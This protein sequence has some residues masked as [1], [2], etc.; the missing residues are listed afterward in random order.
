MVFQNYALFPHKTVAK[1]IAYPLECRRVPKSE[2]HER[3]H[4]ALDTVQL[5]GF[6]ARLPRELSGGQQQR[7]AIARALVFEPKLLLMDEPLGAL[8]RQLREQMQ[9]EIRRLHERLGITVIYVTHDQAEALVMSDRIAVFNQ[10][11]IEQLATPAEL[12]EHPQNS[13]VAQ[14]V[15]ENNTFVGE[16]IEVQKEICVVKLPGNC[17]VRAIP[18]RPGPVGGL[19]ILSIRPESVQLMPSCEARENIFDARICEVIFHGD[20][21]RLRLEVCGNE[22][23]VLKLPKGMAEQTSLESGSMIKVGWRASD[24]RALDAPE[25][26]RAER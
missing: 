16:I 25:V 21:L 20:H 18:V 24:C 5:A 22:E 17:I 2:I 13:F 26:K 6:E 1:N 8:D 15:G 11:R 12:Y 4:A 23:F 19:T 14:F 7:V 10:G 9:Y 3:V